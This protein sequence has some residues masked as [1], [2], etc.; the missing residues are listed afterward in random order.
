MK[1]LIFALV[2]I[3]SLTTLSSAN[4]QSMV[5]ANRGYLGQIPMVPELYVDGIV[6][7]Y[8]MSAQPQ[9]YTTM[10]A[11]YAQYSNGWQLVDTFYHSFTV[12]PMSGT[13]FILDTNFT[14]TN[15]SEERYLLS[16]GVWLGT[17]T[18]GILLDT[19]SLFYP[20]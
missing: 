17:P 14:Q 1:K 16:Q 10:Q 20:W 19:H 9:L 2:A 11:V 12:A 6:E 18:D 4:A 5:T 15:A 3:V 8:N 7:V 13:T